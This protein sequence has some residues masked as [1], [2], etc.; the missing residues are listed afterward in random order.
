MVSTVEFDKFV[1]FD[2]IKIVEFRE[3]ADC[4][5]IEMH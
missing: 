5:D 2:Y 1:E 3:R 4:I